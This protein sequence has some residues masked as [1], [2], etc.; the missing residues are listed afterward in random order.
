ME[1]DG[2]RKRRKREIWREKEKII[3]EKERVT[4]I[5]VHALAIAT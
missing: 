4:N 3:R 5:A 1:R 2:K